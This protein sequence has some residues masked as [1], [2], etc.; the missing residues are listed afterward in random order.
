M[1][2]DGGRRG[3]QRWIPALLF[4]L[5]ALPLL[6]IIVVVA[7]KLSS[8]PLDG[9]AAA[10]APRAARAPAP[11]QVVLRLSG[12][13]T[14]GPKLAPALVQNFM[15]RRMG[16]T[17]I[18]SLETAP[19]EELLRVTLPSGDVG[20]EIRSHGSAHAFA[21]LL[22]GTCDIGMASRPVNA[23]E[24]S[25]LRAGGMGDFTSPQ[26]EFVIGLD[27]LAIIVNA[28]SSIHSLT[29]TQIRQVFGGD[30]RDW[31]DLG[32][33]SGAIATYSRPTTSSGTYDTF[34]A[35]VLDGTGRLKPGTLQIEDSGELVNAVARDPRGIGFVGFG[36]LNGSLGVRPI[37]V[38]DSGTPLREPT[39]MT[40]ATED[41]VLHRRLYFYVPPTKH[42]PLVAQ[43]VAFVQSDEGQ[44]IVSQAGFVGQNI[45]D[46][47][48]RG[49][50]VAAKAPPDD[51]S[52]DYRQLFAAA[53]RLPTTIKFQSGR[54]DL[55]NKASADLERIVRHAA[56]DPGARVILVGFCDSVGDPQ[57]N[58][59]LSLDR[60]RMVAQELD[61]RGVKAEIRGEGQRSP[62][63][64]NE[65][66][67]G[68]EA[69]RRV[70]V[71]VQ[72]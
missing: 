18:S 70:E 13:N 1:P 15:A 5:A 7:S 42:E 56:Y 57:R 64:T 51:A 71:W 55:D 61:V 9:S 8:G 66:E 53:T 35:L 50:Q 10:A 43:F 37:A 32:G 2:R 68:R 72:R 3:I 29:R 59:K 36:Y 22:A 19:E 49:N 41:Y 20:V 11:M 12:S 65:T 48:L 28:A 4:T 27:G 46:N 34:N 45:Q 47:L 14:I 52:P 25:A 24:I 21:D 39:V 38:G 16:A 33:S 40:I 69:N 31:K 23:N 17:L 62:V 63:Q 67:A 6:G 60:A 44:T 26:S 58:L 54:A 30:I